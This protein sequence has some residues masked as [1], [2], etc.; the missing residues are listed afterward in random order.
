MRIMY[1]TLESRVESRQKYIA[2]RRPHSRVTT[3]AIILQFVISRCPERISRENER[4]S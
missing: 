1:I 4:E 2:G 3:D